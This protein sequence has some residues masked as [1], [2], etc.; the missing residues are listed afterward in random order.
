[1][2]TRY[3]M[4]MTVMAA[5]AF[6]G[7]FVTSPASAQ[8]AWPAKPVKVL[9]GLAPG[10]ATDIQARLFSQKLSEDFGRA[11]VVENRPG[12]GELI[13]I[14]AVISSPADGYTALS[15]TTSLTILPA[16]Q[17]KPSYDP[18]KDLAPVSLITKAPYMVVVPAASPAKTMKD[19]LGM[20]KS[21]NVNFGT[22]GPGT[23]IHLGGTWIGNSIGTP[24][25]IVH[26]KGIGPALTALMSNEIQMTFANPITALPQVKAGKFRAL[27]VTSAE[28]S[29]ALTSL[30]TVA[31]SGISGFDVTT[32]HGWLLPRATPAAIVGRLQGAISKMIQAK[33]LS[34]SI[35]SQGGDAGGSTPEQFAQ[36]ISAELPRWSK[37]VRE[38]N[39]KAE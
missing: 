9:V 33:D 28:R 23:I 38:N 35:T 27:A 39:I 31:A 8:D 20:A 2:Q 34:E 22:G 32:W 36:L 1:M 18:L 26:Y 15:V 24:I 13:A 30:G 11:F 10:G 21:G 5:S 6:A 7:V 19:L 3:V 29:K 12:A 16:F 17:E 4:A 14:Q 25:T 37:L